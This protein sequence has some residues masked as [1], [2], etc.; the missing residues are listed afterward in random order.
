[1]RLRFPLIGT[2]V[3]GK[4]AAELQPTV[5]SIESNEDKK[6]FLDVLGGL[7]QFG[8]N[9]LS[10]DKTISTK[11]L[12]A[13]KEWVYRNNDVIAL[14]VSNIEFELYSVGLSKGEIVFRQIEE[15]PLLDLLDKFNTETTKSDGIYIT[16]SDKKL[17]GDAFWYLE[18]N[19]K[20]IENI[21]ILIPDQVEIEF[22]EIG[23]KKGL[24]RRYKYVDIVDSK[25]KEVYYDPQD[26]IHFKK[27]NPRNPFRGL[28]A[29]EALADTIDTDNLTN[30]T[31]RNFF[32]KGAISNFVLT[33][34]SKVTDDQLKRLKAEFRAAYTGAKNAYSTMIFGNGL[35]PANISF[36]NR[37]M[38]YLD[39][40][41][42]YRDKIMIG[43][44]NTKASLGIIDDVNRASFAESH[45]GWLKG[46]VKPDMDSIVNTLNEFLVPKFGE[47]LVLGYKNPIAED[48]TD[49]VKEATEL[50]KAG[51]I[52]IN[53][54]RELVEFDPV[55][56]GD[57]FAPDSSQ[58]AIPGQEQNPHKPG[59]KPPAPDNEKPP[60]PDEGEPEE[61]E[62]LYRTRFYRKAQR[63]RIGNI[64]PAL[65]HLDIE[66][67]L[68][69]HKMFTERKANRDIKEAAK[70]VIR[71]MLKKKSKKE[72][73]RVHSQFTNEQIS[74]YYEKQI[75]IVDVLET[76]FHDT[77]VKFIGK[78]ERKVLA[79]L[80]SEIGTHKSFKLWAK[81]ELFDE[82]DFHVEA[83]LDFTPLLMEEIIL[84]GQQ[85]YDL[86]GVEDTYLPFKLRE[87]VRENVRLFTQSMLDT[88]RESLIK[89][90]V[91]GI[92][93]GSSVPQIRDSITSKF[94]DIKRV[95]A[96]R[97]TRTEIIKASNLAA[98]DAFVQSGVVEAMQWLV[99][100]GACPLCLPYSGKIVGLKDKFYEPENKFQN[101][102]PGS[103]HVMCRCI[104]VPIVIGTRAYQPNHAVQTEAMQQKIA[105]L[106]SQIDKRTKAYKELQSKRSDD[107]VYI[108]SLEKHLGLRDE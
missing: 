99:A 26:V 78:L 91:D 89:L 16:Q 102:Y 100:P 83:Q 5:V 41:E 17:A 81:K 85:V 22:N 80:D 15:H 50:K 65:A 35:K 104:L 77:V 30:L 98:H 67:L 90:I 95:Q 9:S 44:G 59:D 79:N 63:R 14:E 1:M 53:E 106:E 55:K 49:D 71:E 2:V 86:L 6:K 62:K 72:E 36:S 38:Q 70:P 84:A 19:G 93:N 58:V 66:K 82:E 46:T 107:A 29:V 4:D 64:P 60:T 34:E 40:L 43:F 32:E 23:N 3:T 76:Q 103:L 96:E 68:R 87:T 13:N 92:E 33:T 27:P 47:K 97:I 25:R 21:R 37:D 12:Q 73:P 56:G 20:T 88:D 69:K 18:R 51:I 8:T 61:D 10:N 74:N 45:N 52:T 31:Q 57:I 11:L 39:L 24:I 42:W 108:K 7:L 54:A 94:E 28:G 75:H 48:R 105:E 101:G